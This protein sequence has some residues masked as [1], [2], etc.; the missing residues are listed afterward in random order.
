M[1]MAR[2]WTAR[3]ISASTPLRI[4]SSLKVFTASKASMGPSSS[5]IEAA[6]S[7]AARRLPI[8]T[9]CPPPSRK[10][11]RS[12]KPARPKAVVAW[13]PR[14]AQRRLISATL[15]VTKTAY[16]AGPRLS[17]AT[18]PK[19]SAMTF[20]AAAAASTPTRSGLE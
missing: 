12:P 1:P 15:R 11:R 4:E 8:S 5:M 18:T 20:D 7:P 17:P 19:A 3:V 14:A 2:S 9:S 6:V 13:P 16:V 10:T